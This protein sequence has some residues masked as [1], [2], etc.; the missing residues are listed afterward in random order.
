MKN[1]LRIFGPLSV[2]ELCL[3]TVIFLLWATGSFLVWGE[4]SHSPI[5]IAACILMF[6]FISLRW[7][8]VAAGRS[9]KDN[10]NDRI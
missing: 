8:M 10:S 4:R 7:L 3:L 1:V 5:E 2:I 6:L 9:N